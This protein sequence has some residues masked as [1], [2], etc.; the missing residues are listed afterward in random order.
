MQDLNSARSF[1]G[2]DD[3]THPPT[4]G[5]WCTIVHHGIC[6]P[7]TLEMDCFFRS[8]ISRSRTLFSDF[9]FTMFLS[10]LFHIVSFM[11]Y[12]KG[13][14]TIDYFLEPNTNIQTMTRSIIILHP[15]F[16]FAYYLR[17]DYS[18]SL[19]CPK[20]KCHNE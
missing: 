11:I 14:V 9:T 18:F 16:L 6:V 4:K 13:I 19:V 15:V 5:S 7:F 8:F 1:V 2:G 10:R 12:V 3:P 17:Y 20:M